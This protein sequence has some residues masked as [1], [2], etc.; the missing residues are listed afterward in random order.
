M[1]NPDY[2]ERLIATT[3]ATRRRR[4]RA[5]SSAPATS[6]P[7]YTTEHEDVWVESMLST[8]TATGNYPGDRC[9]APTGPGSRPG[10]VGV[11]N[12]LTPEVLQRL[13][14]HRPRAQAA[15]PLDPRHARR[16]SSRTRR[17]TT[18]TTSGRSASSRTG[19]EPTSRPRRRW[20]RRCA[21]CSAC[22]PSA[23]GAVT[24]VALEG[25]GHTAAPRAPGRVPPC[26]ARRDRLRGH[27]PR[28]PRAADRGDHHPLRGLRRNAVPSR[29]A[30]RVARHP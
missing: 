6:P 25:V 19:R 20:C 7:G 29:G 8:S 14:H 18:T 4:R 17:S 30:R 10:T 11:L 2:V 13:G 16:R 3:R 15:D 28:G 26:A 24:E 22:T 21:T 23:G 27:R 1:A 9:R 5:T 12:A